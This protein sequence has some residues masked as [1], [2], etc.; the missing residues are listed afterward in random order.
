M[1]VL[2]IRPWS[3][4]TRGGVPSMTAET[5]FRIDRVRG[6]G[7]RHPEGMAHPGGIGIATATGDQ[8]GHASNASLS[9]SCVRPEPSAPI[10]KI[11]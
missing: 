7:G 5:K 1:M 10:T 6:A 3:P 2:V 8:P 11:S 4:V 9:V